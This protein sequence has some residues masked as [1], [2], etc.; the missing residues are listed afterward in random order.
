MAPPP[1]KKI[2]LSSEDHSNEEHVCLLDILT[3]MSL[4]HI[5]DKIFSYLDREDKLSFASAISNKLHK[6]HLLKLRSEDESNAIFYDILL[7][8][9]P[10]LGHPN[11]SKV[12][13][14]WNEGT[15]HE[16]HFR[17]TY[18]GYNNDALQLEVSQKYAIVVL[19]ECA[20]SK[21]LKRRGGKPSVRLY[22]PLTKQLV[23]KVSI[24]EIF[25]ENEYHL[26]VLWW[27]N[28]FIYC[29][30]KKFYLWDLDS[31]KMHVLHT[32]Y[33]RGSQFFCGSGLITC[34]ENWNPRKGLTVYKVN[35]NEEP[36]KMRTDYGFPGK[37]VRVEPGSSFDC[38]V[39][40]TA[41]KFI[42]QLRSKEDFSLKREIIMS[43]SGIFSCWD[44]SIFKKYP[45]CIDE[46]I[47]LRGG[48]CFQVWCSE[49]EMLVH[50]FTFSSTATKYHNDHLCF[51]KWSFNHL[52]AWSLGG[53]IACW[54]VSSELIDS[55]RK[56]VMSR[57][58]TIKISP[59]VFHMP[60]VS[61]RGKKHDLRWDHF[62]ACW[63]KDKKPKEPV[64]I[65]ILSFL[66]DDKHAS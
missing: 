31:F 47:I 1:R 32:S 45:C 6:S 46:F 22:N 50:K 29:V 51:T 33:P 27:E 41:T 19:K 18:P 26:N 55:W 35:K 54:H 13:Q 2:K 23:N 59:P 53:Q 20:K 15:F 16:K 5:I 61:K 8:G 25:R 65:Q 38:L 63:L 3:N 64:T 57:S 34:W 40:E 39:C 42:V 4:D 28:I 43:E 10:D 9:S 37:I 17:F 58:R 30:H 56:I 66:E 44:I 21:M 11:L 36:K 14:N 49:Y 62:R 12:R 24:P 52:F 7:K 60:K 48:S